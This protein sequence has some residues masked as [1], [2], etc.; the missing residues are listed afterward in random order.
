MKKLRAK[1]N[2]KI[3]L[4]LSITGKE[5]AMHT[6]DSLM[7][8]IG[9]FDTVTISEKGY[10]VYMNGELDERNSVNKVLDMMKEYSLPKVR[11]DIQKGIPFSA[12]LGGSSADM[13][14][15]VELVRQSFGVDLPEIKLGSDVPFMTR[16]GFA[17]VTGIGDK[18]ERLEPIDLHLV[19]AK[20]RGGVNTR[21]AY[22]LFDQNKKVEKC[23]NTAL[24]QALYDKNL[25]KAR[26]NLKNDLQNPAFLLN[27]EVK[28]VYEQMCISTPYTLMSGS[29]SSVFGIFDSEKDA[30]KAVE[31][32]RDK[33][34]YAVYTTTKSTGVEI[35]KA[36]SGKRHNYSVFVASSK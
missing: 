12:G 2:A 31:R 29:G 35:Q 7:H 24:I 28:R 23:D 26:E 33:N 8:S 3:N 4:S 20:G 5:G 36:Q 27:S 32:L 17:R 30:K 25:E 14:A 1:V 11:F 21:D 10:G 16:G 15:A 18:I 34:T 9:I 22:A 19:I 6:L 13:S